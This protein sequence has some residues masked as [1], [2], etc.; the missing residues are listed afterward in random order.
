MS[1]NGLNGSRKERAKYLNTVPTDEAMGKLFP[2]LIESITNKAENTPKKQL[3]PFR[4]DPKVYQNTP[5]SGLRITWMG[6][7]GIL[8]EIDGKRIL[9]DPVWSARASFT[10]M[11]GPKRFF[12]APLPL[13]EL[14]ELDAVLISHD[15]YDHLDTATIRFFA[16]KQ[17]P[18]FCSLGVGFYLE[19]WGIAKSRISEMD[20]GDKASIGDVQ[21]TSCPTRHFSGRGI[22]HRNETLWAAFAIRG[23]KHNIYYGADSGWFNGFEEIGNAYGPF[24][25]TML[26]IGAYGKYWPDIHMGPLSAV[27]AHKALKGKVMMPIHW[28]TF[29]LAPHAWYEP[30]E[31]LLPLAE[32]QN[33]TLFVPEPGAPTEV[34]GAAFNS[35]WWRKFMSE[36]K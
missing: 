13:A 11:I 17:T 34:D 25:L 3:G 5:A 9:T 26:E 8:I 27:N 29:N 18:F 14:P 2:I 4:T 32:R 20:W 35:G 31:K 19:K 1:Y 23:P 33:L 30:I 6:H 10:Q 24:D 15:H 12:P 22:T 16:D 7:S 21:L 28:G 36:T